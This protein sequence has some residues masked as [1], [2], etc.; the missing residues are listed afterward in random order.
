M[1]LFRSDPR[2]DGRGAPRSHALAP[3]VVC[4]CLLLSH[5]VNAAA[6]ESRAPAPLPRENKVTAWFWFGQ[7]SPGR[8]RAP[9]PARPPAPAAAPSAGRRRAPS[10]PAAVRPQTPALAPA[11]APPAPA[12]VVTVMHR[13]SG[14]KLLSLLAAGAPPALEL[15]DL[16]T[17]SD[18]H[19]KVV[20]GFLSDD[21]RTV[22]ARLPQAEV[23]IGFAAPPVPFGFGPA[24]EASGLS[25][26]TLALSDGRR[27]P[28]NFVGFDSATGLSLLEAARPVVAGAV[29]GQA[30]GADPAVGQRVVLYAPAPVTRAAHAPPAA[31]RPE[32]GVVYAS[33]GRAEAF[34]TGVARTPAGRPYAVTARAG[35][36]NPA[37]AGA[38]AADPAGSLVGIVSRTEAGLTQ[39]VPAETV[40]RA[41]E[42]VKAARSVVP[43]PWLGA[44]G[45]S[46]S[47]A[48]LDFWVGHGWN[49][50]RAFAL[51]QNKQGVLLTSV[52]PGTPAALAGL[53][54]GD[55][56][57]GVA[58]REV[59]TVQD[60]SQTLTEQRLDASVEFTVL[61]APEVAPVKVPVRLTGARDPALATAE[62]EARAARER[63]LKLRYQINVAR[64][65]RERPAASAPTVIGAA[66]TALAPEVEAKLEDAFREAAGA[67]RRVFAA[68]ARMMFGDPALAPAAFEDELARRPL[69]TAGLQALALTPRGAAQFKAAGGVLVVSVQPDSP[70]EWC[71]LRAGDVIETADGRN[72]A[73]ADFQKLMRDS[74]DAPV[75]LGVVR[76]GER[77]SLDFSLDCPRKP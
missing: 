38:V 69:L 53:R 50:E 55:L 45:D 56:I 26:F 18:V 23:E 5:A 11:P 67:E 75:T 46:A 37:W 64:A 2:R 25:E 43:Q 30:P 58:G 6:Q 28:L 32:D 52:A 35:D 68:R 54:P 41:V 1:T 77:V 44:R 65:E 49:P 66:P 31:P 47:N 14:W 24:G 76:A 73:R 42:R 72:F 17:P 9:R 7:D 12:R 16:P 48:P 3:L 60:L 19:T 20:A 63:L 13:L 22:V 70:A 21:N 57:S 59:R 33:I 15:D 36:L 29:A 8:M 10:A 40:R 51:I 34:L 71:G 61:R 39:I 27:V 74:W 4:L 62:A